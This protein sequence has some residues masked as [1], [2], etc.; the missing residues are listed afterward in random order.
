MDEDA[1]TDEPAEEVP[2]TKWHWTFLAV[3]SLSLA[4]NVSNA[5]RAFFG[6]VATDIGSYANYQME[7]DEIDEFI[8][9]VDLE[10]ESL[11]EGPQEG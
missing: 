9:D 8:G 11:L 4:A 10:L 1:Y 2:S 5:F 3:R 6:E 7:R